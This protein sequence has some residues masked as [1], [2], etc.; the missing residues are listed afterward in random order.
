MSAIIFC[1]AWSETGP[2]RRLELHHI[3]SMQIDA[4]TE[5]ARTSCLA[6][7]LLPDTPELD[8]AIAETLFA[9]LEL[10][11]RDRAAKAVA[12]AA[13]EAKRAHLRLCG[14]TDLAEG[15]HCDSA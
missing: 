3:T 9:Q 6:A 2:T 10:I 14:G 1:G 13:I 15:E 5:R 12:A 7:G 8:A 4:L 11:E